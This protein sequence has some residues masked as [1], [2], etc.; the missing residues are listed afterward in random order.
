VRVGGRTKVGDV[1]GCARSHSKGY[2]LV[3][4]FG[5]D[6]LA[7]RLIWMI[8]RGKWPDHQVDHRNNIPSDNRWRNLRKADASQNRA[9]SKRYANNTSGH[10]GVS[11]NRLRGKYVASITFRGLSRH[12]GGTFEDPRIAGLAYARAA[13]RI[14]GDFA[15]IAS[16]FLNE[17]REVSGGKLSQIGL[18]RD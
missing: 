6:Y 13:R 1:A 17:D 14:H 12:L 11:F 10:K 9:N 4:M 16:E 2:V 18:R 15:R 7:H 5:R 3:S 8:V